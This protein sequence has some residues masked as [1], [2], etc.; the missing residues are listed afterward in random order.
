MA[1][2]GVDL[3]GTLAV[4]NGWKGEWH[5]G[6]PIPAMVERIRKWLAEAKE[7]KIFTARACVPEEIPLIQAW[8]VEKCNLPPLEVTNAKDFR[9]VELWD[10][11]AIQVIPNTGRPVDGSDSTPEELLEFRGPMRLRMIAGEGHAEASYEVV[12]SEHDRRHALF[13]RR[14]WADYC[15]NILFQFLKLRRGRHG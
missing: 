2:I 6:E 12:I 3:D 8:L 5:I 9:M 11:R 4:Y 1:W 14:R 13:P 10:D 15:E 7:V